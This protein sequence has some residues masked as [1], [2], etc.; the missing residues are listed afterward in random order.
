MQ[1]RQL[2]IPAKIAVEAEG[3]EKRGLTVIFAAW[4]N[5]VQA[6]AAFGDTAKPGMSE[7]IAGL[8]EK[9]M[10][11]WLVSGDSQETT[12]AIAAQ[13]KIKRFAGRARPEDKAS[14]VQRLKS[15]GFRVG[16]VGDG[17]NDSAALA[18]ADVG[19]S[20]GVN[21]GRLM[22]EVADVTLFGGNISR[23]PV[24]L[25]LSRL[26]V[27]AVRQNLILAFLY[28]GIGIP[29][30]VLGM[31]NPLLAVLAMLASSLTVIGNTMRLAGE[32]APFSGA[33]KNDERIMKQNV[34]AQAVPR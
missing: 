17:V 31:L 4:R 30:A 29:L 25:D 20:L 12:A 19:F 28:N 26:L 16:M 9:G 11:I 22:E 27:K 14:L 1:E 8:Q 6:L 24:S 2:D 3:A 23:L 7:L 13:L 32:G 33:A 5:K 10:H 15:Q 21:L 34:A 18:Q